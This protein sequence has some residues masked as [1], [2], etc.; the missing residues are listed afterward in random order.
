MTQIHFPISARHREGNAHILWQ[1][2]EGRHITNHPC[3]QSLMM[4]LEAALG[5]SALCPSLGKDNMLAESLCALIRL[6]AKL[7]QGQVVGGFQI[8]LMLLR[9]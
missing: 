4:D 3:K 5:T 9:Y 2:K 7:K 8:A 6:E 1:R